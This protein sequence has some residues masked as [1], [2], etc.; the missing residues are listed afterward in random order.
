M[1]HKNNTNSNKSFSQ[2]NKINVP[3]F[4]H[5]KKKNTNYFENGILKQKQKYKMNL[6]NEEN[7]NLIEDI[8]DKNISNNNQKTSKII[9]NTKSEETK[10][11]TTNKEITNYINNSLKEDINKENTGIFVVSKRMATDIHDY[12]DDDSS[13]EL[14]NKNP[15]G[16]SSIYM[17]PEK[18]KKYRYYS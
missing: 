15:N 5:V 16:K 3:N 1:G 13:L 2:N 11:G 7:N 17:T 9:F 8:K 18:K 10:I 12:I 6:E 4:V 14:S